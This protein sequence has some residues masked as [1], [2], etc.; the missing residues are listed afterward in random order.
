VTLKDWIPVHTLILQLEQEDLVTRTFRRLDPGRQQAILSAILEEAV[1][2]GPTALNIKRVAER[3]GVSVGSLY[4]YFGNR[5]G[6][7]AFTVE[8]GVRYMTHALQSFRPYLR[9][10]PLREAL[11]WYLAGGVEWSHTQSGLVQFFAR[12]AYGGDPALAESVVRPIAATMREMVR[13][14][15]QEAQDRGEIRL[16]VDLDATVR[17][18]HALTLVAGDSELL[19]YLNTY[20]QL[21][22]ED[23]PAEKVR[24]ALL[25]LIVDGIGVP[26]EGE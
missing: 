2:V 20:T 7:L 10:L 3:A 6:L 19:P 12:A 16:D 4:T 26:R 9:G 18:V 14:I 25:D 24:A 1:E 17:V 21:F 11:G 13:G 22:D 15:L 23:V 5:D 8:L